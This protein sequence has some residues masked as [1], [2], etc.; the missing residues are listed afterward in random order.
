METYKDRCNAHSRDLYF[1]YGQV[2]IKRTIKLA[3]KRNATGI[4][5]VGNM[6]NTKKLKRKQRQC[7]PRGKVFWRLFPTVNLPS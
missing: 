6:T 1:K 5:K 2:A 4:I 3:E 7:F